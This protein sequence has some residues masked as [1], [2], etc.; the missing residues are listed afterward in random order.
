M[1][2][3]QVSLLSNT[4]GNFLRLVKTGLDKMIVHRPIRFPGSNFD[5]GEIK[6]NMIGSVNSKDLTP[7]PEVSR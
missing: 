6:G 2:S 4:Q 5:S 3:C 1:Y 7:G